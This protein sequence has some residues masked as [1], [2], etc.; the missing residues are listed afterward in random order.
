MAHRFVT[1]LSHGV[2]PFEVAVASEVF[3]SPALRERGLSVHIVA[4]VTSQV[5]TAD[6]WSMQLEHDL[7]ATADA[8]TLIVPF[9]LPSGAPDAVLEAIR[10]AY[11]RGTRLVSFC[12]GAL[13]LAQAGVLDG[14]RA[15]THWI[16]VEDLRE[17]PRVEVDPDVLYIDEGQVLTSAGTAAA[18]DLALHIVRKDHGAAVANT[19]ARRMLVPP[20]RDGG[21]AQFLPTPVPPE[22]EGHELAEVMAWMY[23]HLDHQLRITDL[24]RMAAMSTRTFSRRFRELTGTSP[25]RWLRHQRVVQAQEMLETTDLTIDA[26]AGRVG[27]SSAAN[28]REHFSSVLHTTPSAYRNRFR[29]CPARFEPTSL[30]A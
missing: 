23:D 29:G 5:R 28:L 19:V 20:H 27:F 3:G 26:I 12:S 6:G 14:R 9:G 24:A 17:Y 1:V 8:D 22:P 25:A 2:T 13:T 4:G 11:R 7:D 15:T 18:I 10:Q 16:H 30:S 21:Q